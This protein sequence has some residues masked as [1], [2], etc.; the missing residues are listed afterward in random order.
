[1]N[2]LWVASQMNRSRRKAGLPA[3]L[4]FLA[5]SCVA[6]GGGGTSPIIP[7]ISISISPQNAT[8]IAAG[9]QQFTASVSG[10]LNTAVTWSVNGITGGNSAVGAINSA[11]LYTAPSV[12]PSPNTVTL[13][14]VSVASPGS[15]ATASATIINPVPSISSIS[16]TAFFAGSPDGVLTVNGTGFAQQ[17]V[18]M[19][20]STSLVTT[21]VI[22]TQLTAVVPSALLAASGKFNVT[23]V[24]P[25]P[26]GGISAPVTLAVNQGIIFTSLSAAPFTVGTPGTF[27]VTATGAPAPSLSET[28]SLPGG[29]T[30]NASTGVLSGTPAAS[31]AGTY[32]ITFTASS[33]VTPNATQNFT[34][35]VNNPS[36]VLNSISPTQVNSGSASMTLVVLGAQ[37]VPQS[38]MRANGTDLTTTFV[39][40][41]KLMGTVPFTMLAQAGQLSISVF[42]PTPGGG[43][44]SGLNLQVLAVVM[45]SPSTASPLT[46]G[47]TVTFS[48]SVSGT[49]SQSVTW[50]I[51]SNGV[52]LGAGNSTVGTIGTTGLYTSP[53]YVPYPAAITIQAVS[54]FDNTGSGTAAVTVTSPVEDWPKYHRDLANTGHS[55]ETGINT[56]TAPHLKKKWTFATG[57][58]V[59]AS[60]AVATINGTRMVFVGSWDGVFHALDATSGAQVWSYTIEIPPAVGACA[61]SGPDCTRIA[62]SSAVANGYVYFGA[63]N[64]FVYCL[65]A[66]TG[67]LVWKYMVGD[68]TQGAEVW[69]SPA[70]YTA[71]IGGTPKSVVAY[72]LSSHN[73]APCVPGQIE[74]FDAMTGLN[75]SNLPGPLS[76]FN[77]LQ[78][79][80]LGLACVGGGV[81]S[82]P[83]IDTSFGSPILYI[84]TGNPGNSCSPPT[85]GTAD[86]AYTDGILALDG[87]NVSHLLNFYQA[88]SEDPNDQFDFGSSVVLHTTSQCTASGH[89]TWVTEA[90]KG[91]TVFTLPRGSTG[92]SSLAAITNDVNP[93]GTGTYSGETIATPAVIAGNTTS[94]CNKICLPSEYGYLWN[95]EQSGDGTG[96][97]TVNSSAPWPVAVNVSGGCT[98]PFPGGLG[99]C[100]L[101]SAPAAIADVLIFGGGEGNFYV[102]SDSGSKVFSAGTLGLVA[103]GPAISGGRI[104]FGSFD[105]NIYCFSVDGQ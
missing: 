1:V 57:G 43:T 56:N 10:T 23:V 81:W 39:S 62:S 76:T 77:I 41:T 58:K 82:S 3:V 95:L 48:A 50:S 45:V 27:T 97:V 87:A 102:Y 103:S 53:A 21:F 98:P 16:P 85:A 38:I 40:S 79:C 69:T 74:L 13:K 71:T 66:A 94:D 60:P 90:N 5:L 91:G 12:P 67:A 44:S 104:Y 24:N 18:V 2:L 100:P 36:P 75:L 22:S 105:K 34:L 96:N 28:G 19:W 52:N 51:S 64:G 8:V 17:A 30:F 61:G 55:V 78:N 15:A 29:V 68:P 37:F 20:G 7:P 84:G 54:D 9:S 26:G 59:S 6:C 93:D 11:G 92:F 89:L 101:F 14:A 99:S 86:T 80:P 72:A 88:Y 47:N 31:T 65:N 25:S 33:G 32:S 49:T 73:D 46:G 63:G 4:V 70:V 35:T 42:S 83:A